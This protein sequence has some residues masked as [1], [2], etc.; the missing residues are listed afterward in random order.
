LYYDKNS[1]YQALPLQILSL[2][3]QIF[4]QVF[5]KP[6]LITKSISSRTKKREGEIGQDFNTSF[7]KNIDLIDFKRFFIQKIEKIKTKKKPIISD[8]LAPS[9][10]GSCNHKALIELARIRNLMI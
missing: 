7:F 10:V 4:L 6:I 2:Y 3:F 5:C 8:R 9:L 1:L